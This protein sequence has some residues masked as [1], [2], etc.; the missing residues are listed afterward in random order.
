MLVDEP[1]FNNR[2]G[3]EIGLDGQ[4][5][6]VGVFAVQSIEKCVEFAWFFR[7]HTESEVCV[8]YAGQLQISNERGVPA[9]HDTVPE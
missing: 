1:S 9:C 6:R 2:R 7:A 8:L 3:V 4:P 5:S